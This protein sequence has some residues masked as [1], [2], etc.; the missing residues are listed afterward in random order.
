MFSYNLQLALKSLKDKPSLTF[1]VVIAIGIGLGLFTT[2]QTM[3]YQTAQIPIPHK[4]ENLFLIQMDNRETSADK[5]EVQARLVDTTYKDTMNLV[6]LPIEGVQHTFTWKTFG[7]ANVEDQNVTPVNSRALVGTHEMFDMFAMPF[8]YGGAWDKQA[9]ESG[10]GVVVLSKRMNDL[11][12]AGVNSVGQTFRLNTIEMTVVGV[13]DD[14]YL[15]RRFYDR[16]Y[17]T[18]RPD[19][20]FIPYSLALANEL[21]RNAGFDCWENE[22]D[23]PRDLTRRFQDQLLTSECAWITLWAEIP[24]NKLSDYEEQ[25]HNYIDSQRDLGRFPRET[26]TFITNLNDQLE[27][28]NGRNGFV[29]VFGIISG[30]FFAVCLLNAIG[31]LL[32]KFLRRTKEVSLRRALGAKKSTIVV[33]HLIEVVIISLMGGVVGLVVAYFGLDGMLNIQ[34]YA[35]DYQMKREDLAPLFKLDWVMMR[36]AFLTSILCTVIAS[37]YP[38]WRVCKISPASQ[39]KSQ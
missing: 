18:G 22:F 39:L 28:I 20:I 16:S 26:L 9:D 29:I 38:I 2:I 27:Y 14:W 10:A 37:I 32:A 4:S 6:N 34:L 13:L 1:L 17:S 25:L 15:T 12:F 31:I 36:N 21:P 23:N 35:S 3:G 33:Q 7:I 5:V 19:D 11:M 8:L 24:D 30:L